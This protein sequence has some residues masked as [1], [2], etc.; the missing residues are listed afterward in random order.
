MLAEEMNWTITRIRNMLQR[1]P[2]LEAVFD[3]DTLD[4]IPFKTPEE[5][6]KMLEIAIAQDFPEIEPVRYVVNEVHEI[7][8]ESLSPAFY[9]KPAL[10]R[11]YE[12]IIY[13]NPGDL[14]DNLSMFTTLAHEGYPGHMYQTV[15]FLQQSPHP[16]RSVLSVKGYTEGWATYAEQLSYHFTGLD[17]TTAEFMRHLRFFDLL[18]Y[19][20]LDLGVNALG[21]GYEEAAS[22]LA[23][24][25]VENPETVG[26]LFSV[27]AGDPLLYLPYC[28]GY[29]EI[30]SLLDEAEKALRKDFDLKEFHRFFLDF[31]PAPFPI[32]REHMQNWIKEQQGRKT[33]RPA[34]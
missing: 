7:L 9:L 21:W 32:I 31:G 33:L 5:Y 19:A 2:D 1:Y 16:L 6:L 30:Q 28:L 8:Q 11:H 12:N 3:S 23:M 14:T 29:L 15:Y 22:F 26:R 10:D 20:R 4:Y 24:L 17:D 34:A 25:G 13:I 18:L 27:V